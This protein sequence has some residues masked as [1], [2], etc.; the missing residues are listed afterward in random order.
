VPFTPPPITKTSK[1]FIPELPEAYFKDLE[2]IFKVISLL[3]II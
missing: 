3:H 2:C 1:S